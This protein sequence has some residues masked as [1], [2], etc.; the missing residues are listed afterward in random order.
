MDLT[1]GK[2]VQAVFDGVGKV[3]FDASLKSLARLGYM[4]SFGN[5]SG[6]VENFDILALS[7]GNLRL[8]RPT[9]F[10]FIKERSEF[11]QCAWLPHPLLLACIDFY[12]CYL[13]MPYS[14]CSGLGIIP[15]LRTGQA[16]NQYPP[17]L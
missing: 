15:Y 11:E 4:I 17:R 6:K 1:S 13:I 10:E 12:P 3:T 5:A 2:G 16:E 9:L 14:P 8:M 7:K